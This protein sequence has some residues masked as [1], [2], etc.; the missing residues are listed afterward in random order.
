MP[1]HHAYHFSTASVLAL[2]LASTSVFAETESNSMA[3]YTT[4]A[5][6]HRML[7]GAYRQ[8][9]QTPDLVDIEIEKMNAFIASAKNVGKQ[10]FGVEAVESEFLLA[11]REDTQLMESQI[12]RNYK[13]IAR[14][15]IN[16]KRRCAALQD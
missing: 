13:N 9:S 11:W 2:A 8:D 10:T 16:H 14:L 6:Y 1:K 4:C 5:V 3:Q 15:R 7:A 12:N